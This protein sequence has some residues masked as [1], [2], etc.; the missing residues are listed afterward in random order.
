[1]ALLAAAWAAARLLI[2]HAPVIFFALAAGRALYRGG[3]RLP[4]L[5]SAMVIYFLALC[6]PLWAGPRLSFW[7]L[8]AWAAAYGVMGIAIRL[9]EARKADA[10]AENPGRSGIAPDPATQGGVITIALLLTALLATGIFDPRFD[11]DPLTYQ[12]YFAATWL[13]DGRVSIVPTPFGDPS[14]AYGPALASMYYLWLMAPIGNDMLAQAGQW[15]FL[16]LTVLAACGLA[17][18]LGAGERRAFLAGLF[19]FMAPLTVYEGRS[20]LSDLAT[21]GFFAS[22]LYFLVRAGRVRKPVDLALGLLA[23]GLMAGCKFTAAPLLVLL[24]PLLG[25]AGLRARGRGAWAAWLAGIAAAMAGGGIWCAR[26]WLIAGNPFFP[27]SISVMGHEIFPGLYGREQML[28]WVFHQEGMRAW[29]DVMSANFSPLLLGLGALALIG[30]VAMRAGMA[31]PAIIYMALL[32]LL[33][34]RMYWEVMPFQVDRFWIPAVPVLA[35]ALAAASSW[36]WPLAV[37]ALALAYAGLFIFPVPEIPGPD[38][39]LWIKIA[40]PFSAAAG[41]ALAFAY[42]RLCQAASK[43]SPATTPSAWPHP[44]ALSIVAAAFFFLITAAGLR[45]YEYRR[46]AALSGLKSGPGWLALPC[47]A[48]GATV[49][50]TG[51]NMPYPL[52]G[53]RLQNR[54]EYV[55]PSG[56][57]MPLDHELFRDMGRQAPRFQTPE[58][59]LSGLSLAKEQWAHGVAASGADYLFVTRLSRNAL[60]NTAHDPDGWPLEDSWA[61]SAPRAFPPVYQDR[62]TRIYQVDRSAPLSLPDKKTDRPADAI[63]ACSSAANP[64]CPRFFPLAPMALRSIQTSP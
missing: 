13:H 29:R 50:Y 61:R 28:S 36:R 63:A 44:P 23:A 53:P 32:P 16:L 33:I 8:A 60:L 26:N 11:H 49:A 54:V 34:D 47:S 19:I 25:F 27:I 3:E 45:S 15:P 30:L 55:S 46:A 9:W 24:L 51:A 14:Q 2:L 42:R 58:P 22:S 7:W 20:A 1:M 57:V 41:L 62:F 38:T 4:V 64:D 35:A 21:A 18:E 39:L 5:V 43:K 40:L 37:A 48:G 59:M 56:R 6:L 52:L 17:D 10:R 31:R 12:L